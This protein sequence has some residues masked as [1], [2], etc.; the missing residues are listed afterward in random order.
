M[1]HLPWMIPLA[2]QLLEGLRVFIPQVVEKV[3]NNQRLTQQDLDDIMLFSPLVIEDIDQELV[4]FGAAATGLYLSKTERGMKL[5]DTMVKQYFGAISDIVSSVAKGGS[6]HVLSSLT[7]QMTII[8][9]M[10]RLG[11]ISAVEANVIH[12]ELW[13]TI[14]KVVAM[15]MFGDI[16]TA[17]GTVFGGIGKGLVQAAA[18]GA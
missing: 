17:A 9:M 18:A 12:E 1:A 10:R 13:W 8:R 5:L 4:M 11:L 14:N 3:D 15:E 6:T 16:T 2:R 7:A